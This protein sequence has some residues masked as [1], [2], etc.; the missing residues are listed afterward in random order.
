MR[1]GGE[2]LEEGGRGDE[3]RGEERRGVNQQSVRN[4]SGDPV[5][6]PSAYCSITRWKHI[7]KGLKIMVDITD[8]GVYR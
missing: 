5:S 6:V 7:N 8:E 2:Q 4:L 3:K 1:G